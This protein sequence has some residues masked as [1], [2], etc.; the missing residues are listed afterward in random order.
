[1]VHFRAGGNRM[2]TS[3]RPFG[4]WT[5]TALVVGGMV[6]SGIFL[7]PASLAPFGWLGTAAWAIS[8][9]GALAIAWALARLAREMSE[10]TGAIA[11][12]GAVLG[13]LPGVLVGWTYWISVWGANAAIAIAA[14][15]YLAVFVPALNAT[16]LTGALT[17]IGLIWLLTLLNLGGARLAGQFQVASTLL[18]LI[19][20][21]AV[22]AIAATLALGGVPHAAQL[23]S[24][25]SSLG[26]LT[27]AVTLTMFALIGFEA[28]G[29]AAERVRDPERNVMRATMT[30]T[31]LTGLLYVLVCLAMVLFLPAD[32]LTHA[33]APFALFVGTYLGTGP[34][35]AVSAFA[36]IAAIGALNGWVLIQGEVPLG[37]ARAGLL[38]AWFARVNARDVPVRVL[39][40]SSTLSSILVYSNSSA[41]LGKIFEFVALLTT[42]SNLWFYAAV[43][44][45]ALVKRVAV[46]VAAL[47]LAFS[48][49]A[50]VG[51]GIVPSALSLALMLTAVPVYLLR[52][53]NAA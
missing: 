21:V 14:T 50:I 24:N 2:T 1:M 45:A 17:S 19:P 48:I 27:G 30:G 18:K 49:W 28:A 42:S 38:P 15:S 33:S 53:R 29:V 47:G 32:A 8:V 40:V 16:P 46:P 31:A 5:A 6:G 7:L 39:L 11:I 10:Q 34:A 4:F 25:E 22:I 20:L 9:G 43:C 3:Q 23:P 36:A 13:T 12:T 51:A 41:S 26:S 52:R 37:M 44:V 35:L